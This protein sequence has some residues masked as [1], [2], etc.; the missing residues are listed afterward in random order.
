MATVDVIIPAFNAAH[1]LP[2]AIESVV[3]QT[4]DDWQI[5]LV[6]DGSTDNTAEVVAPFL[7]RLGSKIKIHQAK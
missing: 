1:Y 5:L 6:D 3:S 4:F 7:K 2:A